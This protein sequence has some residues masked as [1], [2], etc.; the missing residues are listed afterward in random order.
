MFLV[1]RV[2]LLLDYKN[3]LSVYV[4]FCKSKVEELIN[5]LLNTK[6]RKFDWGKVI[7]QVDPREPF[8]FA[9]IKYYK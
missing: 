9:E 8:I 7:L 3:Y 1:R 5:G 4:D 2:N 6:K